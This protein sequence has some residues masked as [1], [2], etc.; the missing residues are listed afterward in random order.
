MKKFLLLFILISTLSKAQIIDVLQGHIG[1]A[2]F[3]TDEKINFNTGKPENIYAGF[4]PAQVLGL[5]GTKF[6]TDKIQLCATFDIMNTFKNHYNLIAQKTALNVKYNFIAPDIYRFSPYIF[7]GG[8]YSFIFLSQSNFIRNYTPPSDYKGGTSGIEV[9]EITYRENE[10][11]FLSPVL[12]GQGGIGVDIN[13]FEVISVFGELQY[14]YLY[15]TKSGLQN[16]F[17][18]Y[19]KSDFIYYQLNTGVRLYLY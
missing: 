7:L 15:T 11:Q 9:N 6:I 8:N 3:P 1:T 2:I 14:N 12:G 4:A 17:T 18:S 19:N 5:G 10:Y 16:E 13:V